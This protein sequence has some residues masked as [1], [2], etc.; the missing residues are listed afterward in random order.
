MV[1]TSVEWNEEGLAAFKLRRDL[2]I[3]RVY[4]KVSQ[5]STKLQELFA[6]WISI[7]L[8][9]RNCVK[10]ILTCEWILQLGCEDR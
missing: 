3:V 7:V 10:D 5:A 9:L 1:K 8:V 2:Y 4:G 6:F